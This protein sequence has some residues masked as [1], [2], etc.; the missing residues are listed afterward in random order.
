[1]LGTAAPMHLNHW[2]P[3]M[4]A[5]QEGPQQTSPTEGG[6]GR[7]EGVVWWGQAN[8]PQGFPS[9]HR[10]EPQD[11]PGRGFPLRHSPREG[12]RMRRGF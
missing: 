5:H 8:Q 1:M 4:W 9:L 12:G 10:E 11:K 6:G 2:F 3:F 7:R